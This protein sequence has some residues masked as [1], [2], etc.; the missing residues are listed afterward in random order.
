MKYILLLP[1]LHSECTVGMQVNRRLMN[2]VP[3]GIATQQNLTKLMP[4]TQPNLSVQPAAKNIVPSNQVLENLPKASTP[5][6]ASQELLKAQEQLNAQMHQEQSIDEAADALINFHPY[7][8]ENFWIFFTK[9]MYELLIREMKD[10]PAESRQKVRHLWQIL[11]NQHTFTNKEWAKLFIKILGFTLSIPLLKIMIG[12]II[13][14]GI[15]GYFLWS[16]Y[17][18]GFGPEL[19]DLQ[20]EYSELGYQTFVHGRVW[21]WNYINDVWNLITALKYYQTSVDLDRISLRF[22]TPYNDS[23]LILENYRKQLL[24]HG[25]SGRGVTSAVTEKNKNSETIFMNKN[26][27]SNISRKSC[28][29]GSYIIDNLDWSTINI[30]NFVAAMFQKQGISSF[31]KKYRTELL[32]LQELHEK[33]ST[34]GELLLIAVDKKHVDTMI[35]PARPRGYQ[36]GDLT[37]S[38]DLQRWSPDPFAAPE[39][40]VLAVSDKPALLPQLLD[41]HD[42]YGTKE[43]GGKYLIKSVKRPDLEKYQLYCSERDALF[44]KML[45]TRN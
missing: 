21:H 44:A 12:S 20:E 11:M 43:Q 4:T 6:T 22:R 9:E 7:T 19:Y 31:Y 1:L 23:V 32:E 27:W 45:Q 38:V 2:K 16:W 42:E 29:T 5:L 24:Q 13:M 37:T 25:V 40:Y 10:F 30:E 36:R 15:S 34:L 35:Y 8:Q 28:C 17:L 26:F 39:I 14:G 18:T 33:S 41:S 3:V